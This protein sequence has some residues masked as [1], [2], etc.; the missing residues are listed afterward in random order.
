M[1]S[2][3]HPQEDENVL[4]IIKGDVAPEW[5]LTDLVTKRYIQTPTDAEVIVFQTIRSGG[6]ISHDGNNGPQVLPQASVD[7]IPVRVLME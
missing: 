7:A 2:T 3:G 4:H 5:W 1:G 6:R